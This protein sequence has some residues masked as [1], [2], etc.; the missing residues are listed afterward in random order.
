M[1]G[2]TLPIAAPA[3]TGEVRRKPLPQAHRVERR[4]TLGVVVEVDEHVVT[5]VGPAADHRCPLVEGLVVVAG[6][7]E[8]LGTVQPDIDVVAGD[9][10]EARKLVGGVGHDRC[11]VVLAEQVGGLPGS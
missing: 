11:D 9:G 4:M 8:L 2:R 5:G 3:I 10:V 6:R 7:V 1:T